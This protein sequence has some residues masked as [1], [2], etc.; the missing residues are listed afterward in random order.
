MQLFKQKESK[1]NQLIVKPII[2]VPEEERNITLSTLN[3][4]DLWINPKDYIDFLQ[5]AVDYLND[6]NVATWIYNLPLCLF[7]E[8]YRNKLSGKSKGGKFGYDTCGTVG[9]SVACQKQRKKGIGYQKGY[10]IF[11][12]RFRYV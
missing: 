10:Q 4:N 7:S 2:E 5:K 6:Y 9:N 11:N 3:K 8:K 12:T 1:S